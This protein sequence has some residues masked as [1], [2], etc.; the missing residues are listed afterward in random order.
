MLKRYVVF[1]PDAQRAVVYLHHWED[2]N[3]GQIANMLS[4]PKSTAV[5]RSHYVL[6]KLRAQ[7]PPDTHVAREFMNGHKVTQQLRELTLATP[8]ESW[9][10]KTLT[11][12]RTIVPL[13]SSPK[14]TTTCAQWLAKAAVVLVEV[15]IVISHCQGKFKDTRLDI[16]LAPFH[17]PRSILDSAPS[18]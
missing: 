7:R 13:A 12:P 10:N 11:E 5:N 9:R 4:I 2:L 14:P 18:D 17:L 8:P 15:G 16:Y 1:L 6:E 3:F